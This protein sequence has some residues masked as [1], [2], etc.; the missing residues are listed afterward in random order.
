LNFVILSEV[1]GPAA[2][3]RRAAKDPN[4]IATH[5]AVRRFPATNLEMCAGALAASARTTC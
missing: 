2:R 4:T 1:A 3:D 5:D